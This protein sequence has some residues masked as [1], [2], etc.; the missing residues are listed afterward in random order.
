MTRRN[1]VNA[2]VAEPVLGFQANFS[3][4]TYICY[5]QAMNRLDLKIVGSGGQAHKRNF[6]KNAFYSTTISC[7]K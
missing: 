2:V 5:S 7:I 3:S 1:L 6:P 4:Y